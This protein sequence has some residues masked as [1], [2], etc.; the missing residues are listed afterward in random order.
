MGDLPDHGGPWKRGHVRA[1]QKISPSDWFFAAHLLG[2]PC[3]PGFLLLE[4]AGQILGFHLTALGF[5]LPRDG[6]RFEPVLD[7]AFACRFRGQVE[8]QE[9]TLV[10]DVYIESLAGDP[11]PMVTADIICSLDGRAVFHGR[12]LGLR[13]VPDWPLQQFR[14]NPYAGAMTGAVGPLPQLAGLDGYAGDPRAA[15]LPSGLECGYPALLSFAVGKGQDAFGPHLAEQDG[16]SRWARLPAPPFI[17]VR[18]WLWIDGIRVYQATEVGV[19]IVS[20]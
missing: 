8:P 9:A 20:G 10:Y 6:W 16:P 13:L 3:M 4:A 19:R 2:D 1:T 7:Q 14:R 15:V 17:I 12:N 11:L 5:T 18:G